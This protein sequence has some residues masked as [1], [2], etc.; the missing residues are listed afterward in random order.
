M[1]LSGSTTEPTE[2]RVHSGGADPQSEEPSC[3]GQLGNSTVGEDETV[4]IYPHSSRDRKK[5]KI[6]VLLD[7]VPVLV[8]AE[9]R[10]A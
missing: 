2:G 4:D 10:P 1:A 5:M 8:L 9:A 3:L 7:S 6:E